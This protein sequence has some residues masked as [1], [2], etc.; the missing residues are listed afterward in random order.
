M[1]DQL[2]DG[3]VDVGNDDLIVPVPQVDGAHAAARAL[4]LGGD[5]E[6]DI[7]E[8]FPQLQAGLVGSVYICLELAE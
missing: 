7:V 3:A 8:S 1:A 5:A 2:C 6:G 4:V